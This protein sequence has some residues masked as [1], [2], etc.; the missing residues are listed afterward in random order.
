MANSVDILSKVKNFFEYSVNSDQYTKW[1]AMSKESYQFYDGLQWTEEEIQE[2]NER[3][4][5]AIVVNK[6]A[7]K[8]D[9]LAGNEKQAATIITFRTRTFD[10][11]DRIMAEAFTSIGVNWQENQDS[12]YKNSASFS[13]SLV[14]GIGW[15]YLYSTKRN[16][17]IHEAIDPFEMGWDVDD[18]SKDMSNQRFTWR[19]KWMDI[20][21]V[22]AGFPKQLEA[23]ND[24]MGSKDE[25]R[26]SRTAITNG[27]SSEHGT[28]MESYTNDNGNQLAV[29]EV[30]YR[31]P[32]TAY[33]FIDANNRYKRVFDQKFA[34]K[35]K[36]NGSKVTNVVA[37]K[38]KYAFYTADILLDHG[39]LEEQDEK[40]QYIPLPHK[41]RK[42]TGVPYGIIENGKDIQREINKRR[43]KT[44]HYLNTN[45]VIIEG[46]VQDVEE[47]RQEAARPDGVMVVKRGS[48]SINANLQLATGQQAMYQQSNQ[49]LQDVMGVFD[50]S[51]GNETNATSGI[52]IARRDSSSQKTNAIA[53]DQFKIFKKKFGRKIMSMIQNM[54]SEV[55]VADISGL[56]D[57]PTGETSILLNDVYKD[58][59]KEVKEYDVKTANFDI[60]VEESA[61]Y[62]AP[63]AEAAERLI[64][65]LNSPQLL[66]VLANSPELMATLGIR[67]S[68]M[69]SQQIKDAIGGQPSPDGQGG[70]TIGTPQVPQPSPTQ[71]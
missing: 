10:P 30:Q 11:T 21:E 46:D 28:A 57:N 2:L 61:A 26:M 54:D 34:N 13:D 71:S 47:I 5:P 38:I 35:N 20:E 33:E 23:I 56:Q 69:I 22:R 31:E 36:R 63:P 45:Q 16:P 4:Q 49:E 70:E 25:I 62:D 27:K 52:A 43:S 12:V 8:V 68:E 42:L 9:N 41:R 15:A 51:L 19:R 37:F 58:G 18:L 24:L 32:T 1:K 7:P 48:I 66:P 55:I 3:S 40:F 64:N 44:M 29:I 17:F 53:F 67:N 6:L 50:E 65:L 14:G 59:R 60:Y 39:S